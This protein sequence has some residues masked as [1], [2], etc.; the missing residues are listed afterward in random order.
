M[1]LHTTRLLRSSTAHTAQQQQQQQLLL[2][3]KN[4]KPPAAAAVE[5]TESDLY[6]LARMACCSNINYAAV[7][8]AARH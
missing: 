1:P 3:K 2:Q 8:A 7:V 5:S 4:T 6:V